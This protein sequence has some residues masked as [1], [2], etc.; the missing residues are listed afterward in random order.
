M[1]IRGFR[2]EP[3]EIEATLL[4]H[5][6]IR[7][8]AVCAEDDERGGLRLVAYIVSPEAP[9]VEELRTFLGESLPGHMIP[10]AFKT[11]EA[12]PLTASGKVDR[13]A[14]AGIA[15]VQAKREAEY[16]APRDEVERQ[17][18]E[19]WGEL[20]GVEQV[21]ALDDFF[22]LGGHS[23]LAAQATMRIRRLYADIPLRALL[24]APTV[25]ALAD[26]IRSTGAADAG[27]DGGQ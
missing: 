10:S 3:G 20:L 9:A 14:L 21:G 16:V 4:A 18:A 7:Q 23:L 13:R 17:I 15:E 2:I 12:L 5:S 11:V 8:V 1:K 25:A 26:V 22:A 24:A 19:I 6:A 27:G